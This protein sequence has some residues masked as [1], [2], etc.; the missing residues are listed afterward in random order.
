MDVELVRIHRNGMQPHYGGR[1]ISITAKRAD[2]DKKQEILSVQKLKKSENKKLPF[3]ITAQEPVVLV[4]KRRRTYEKSDSFL[5][6]NIH[7]K[8]H[9]NNL[10]MPN[11]DQYADKLPLLTN[12]DVRQITPDHIESLETVQKECTDIVRS[13]HGAEFFATGAKVQ[14]IAETQ[15]LL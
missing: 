10:I 7:T 1:P 8:V 2:R 5:S 9:K 6:Q 11:G 3:S 13:P 4:E 15:S 12:S 14:S